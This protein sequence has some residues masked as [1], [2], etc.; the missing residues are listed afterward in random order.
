MPSFLR[1]SLL[2]AACALAACA[3]SPENGDPSDPSAQ[4]RAD[5]GSREDD[6]NGESPRDAGI[7]RDASAPAP[8]GRDAGNGGSSSTRDAGG[9]GSTTPRD[10]GSTTA[11]NPLE[12]LIN[13]IIGVFNPGTADAGRRD[14]G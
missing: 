6:D 9:G 10:A 5:G 3:E 4:E 14:G 11:A 7:R 13:G 2:A 8:S 12:D 1:S